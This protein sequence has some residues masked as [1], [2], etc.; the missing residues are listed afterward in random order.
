ML[1]GQ[2][3]GL[4]TMSVATGAA[5]QPLTTRIT[6][7]SARPAAAIVVIAL[8]WI[9]AIAAIA[10]IVRVG[11]PVFGPHEFATLYLLNALVWGP[12]SGLLISRRSNAIGIILATMAIGSGI[13]AVAQQLSRLPGTDLLDLGFSQHVLERLWMPGTLASF[14]IGPLLLTARPI[15]RWTRALVI[16]GVVAA[17]VPLLTSIPRQRPTAAPNPLAIDLPAVQD[18]V[19]VLFTSALAVSVALAIVTDLVLVWRWRRGPADD[20][21][22]VG[23][24]VIGQTLL[25]VFF[26]PTFLPWLPAPAAF[27]SQYAPLVPTLSLVF[28]V[29]AVVVTALGQRLWGI[30]IAVNRVVVDLLLLLVLVLVYVSIAIPAS[31]LLP[32]PPPIAGAAGVAALVLTLEPLRRWVQR[33]VDALVYGEAADPAQLVARLGTDGHEAGVDGLTAL[34]AELRTTLRL[35]ALEVRSSDPDG[36]VVV[37]GA[38]G[39]PATLL[40][41]R[42]ASTVVGWVRAS[43]AGRQRVDG[44]TRKV[45]ERISGV[46]VVALQLETIN[47]GLAE[48]RDRALGVGEEERRM[49]RRELHDGLAPAIESSAARLHA[50][51]SLL[52][53]DPIL[54]RADLR[55]IQEDLAVRTTEVRDLARTLLPGALDAGD[56][57]AALRELASRFSSHRLEI[58]VESHG[59]NT[60]QPA[61]QGAVHHLAAEAVLLLRRASA[62]QH[63][64]I[65]VEVDEEV[66]RIEVDADA[67]FASGI[68]AGPT[69]RSI[70]DRA[71]ELGGTLRITDDGARLLVE[72]P[73]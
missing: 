17:L 26:S 30:D 5:A 53:K 54:A 24:L 12:V 31:I 52:E 48:V 44:R 7:S 25:V 61:R 11:Y 57:D 1:V 72:V 60:L 34:V 59:T 6:R 42:N 2:Q 27:W 8:S 28:M 68:A 40:T 9:P 15:A 50:V 65:L 63:A 19:V 56:L 70:E 62:V 49:L 58:V 33:R 13:S 22:G 55:R 23:W 3:E 71:D 14:S 45:L 47:R 35:G 32:V 43:S 41:L 46:L 10:I 67:P 21:R 29:A 20:R 37:V 36:P 16:T 73:R 18:I 4:E 39:G 66:A 69:V 64:T 38:G 51:P